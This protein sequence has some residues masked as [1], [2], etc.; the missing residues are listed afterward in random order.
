MDPMTRNEIFMAA[1]AGEFSGV[2]KSFIVVSVDVA[3]YHVEAFFT[4]R[5]RHIEPEDHR[6]TRADGATRTA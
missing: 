6:S 5:Q 3:G 4:L 1:A 2:S